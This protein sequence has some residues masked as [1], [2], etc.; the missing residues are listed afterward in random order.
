[1]DSASIGSRTPHRLCAHLAGSCGGPAAKDLADSY[2]FETLVRLH[3]AGEGEPYTGLK[4]ATEVDP[5]VAAADQALQR[6]SPDAL[7][8]AMTD[9][10]RRR[11]VSG[12]R[13]LHAPARR[14]TK[15]STR[16]ATMWLPISASCT[17]W[18]VWI[19]RATSHRRSNTN[20]NDSEKR[21]SGVSHLCGRPGEYA[22]CNRR[23]GAATV[24]FMSGRI[25]I[26][27]DPER[28]DVAAL[29]KAIQEAGYGVQSS[30][31]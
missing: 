4:P 8:R 15:A 29:V 18:N 30:T 23:C 22:A 3:R 11:S 9:K 24:H 2:F 14:R 28:I 16:V 19:R 10:M 27:H 25:E 12:S 31:L 13:M 21:R 5:A 26:H 6:G 7:V 20:D 17:I 1:M